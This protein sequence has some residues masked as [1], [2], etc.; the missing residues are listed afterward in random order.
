MRKKGN[1]DVIHMSKFERISSCAHFSERA[2]IEHIRD[3]VA[4]FNHNQTD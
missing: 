2:L 4:R 3:G 1:L